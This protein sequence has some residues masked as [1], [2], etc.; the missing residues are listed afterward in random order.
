MR[1]PRKKREQALWPKLFL[2]GILGFQDAVGGEKDYITRSQFDS[3]FIVLAIGNESQ[4]DAFETNRLHTSAADEKRIRAAGVG[5]GEAARGSIVGREEHSDEARV[6][7]VVIQTAIESREHFRGRAQMSDHVLAEYA[8][9]ERAVER[10]SGAFAGNVPERE[11]EPALSIGEEI[12]KITPQFVRGNICRGEV[13]TGN[14]ARAVRKQAALNLARHVEILLETKLRVARFLIEAGVFERDGDIGAQRG[15]H[16]LVLQSEGVGLRAFKIENSDEPVAQ[17][18]RHDELGTHLNAALAADV[19]RII[20]DVIDSQNT[21][22][23]CGRSREP[24]V[25]RY[26]RARGKGIAA[27]HGKNALQMLRLLVPE[28]DTKD[29]IL[30]D[31]LDS[32]GHTAEELFAFKDGCNFTADFIEQGKGVGLLRVGKEQALR[33]GISVTQKRK[34]ADF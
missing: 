32:L 34:R 17:Q 28:H 4:R 20:R 16:A 19:A 25:E 21:P 13:Q 5:E 27:A 9:G 15:K 2:S 12:V 26:A 7:P 31:F 30:Y 23:A 14:F 29:V 33:D 10:G 11:A 3:G 22:L 8:D 1:E 24:L 6:E 18:K